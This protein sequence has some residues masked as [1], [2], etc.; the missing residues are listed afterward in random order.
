MSKELGEILDSITFVAKS[1][2]GVMPLIEYAKEQAE[3]VSEYRKESHELQDV[4]N[5]N[6]KE[7]DRLEQQ[8]KRYREAIEKAKKELEEDIN[9]ID[10][11]RNA[12][13]TISKASEDE[14]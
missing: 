7:I 1:Y 10:C 3:R 8:N 9:I 4:N 12:H 2:N 5:K 11:V 13:Y 6:F 14:E